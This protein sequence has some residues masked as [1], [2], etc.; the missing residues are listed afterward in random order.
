MSKYYEYLNQN[1][2]YKNYNRNNFNLN[3]NQYKR[4]NSKNDKK[5]YNAKNKI[6]LNFL[7]FIIFILSI[8]VIGKF[9]FEFL[10]IFNLSINSIN[11]TTDLEITEEELA[12]MISLKENNL[13][14]DVNTKEI[15]KSLLSNP[16]IKEVK[17]KKIFP[18]KLNIDIKKREG[19]MISFIEQDNIKK[20][21]AIDEEGI[22]FAV[23]R[24]D[25]NNFDLP[26][27]SGIKFNEFYKGLEFN[28]TI[29]KRFI[30]S[31]HELK[32]INLKLF[33]LISECEIIPLGIDNKDL[34]ILIYL[35]NT[36]IPI[37]IRSNINENMIKYMLYTIDFLKKNEKDYNKIKEID[38]RSDYPVYKKEI[39][40]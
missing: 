24:E 29:I 27:L 1:K 33:S 34:E 37:R 7:I 19:L 38:F 10:I 11:L 28:S 14:Y 17:V 9:L 15:E 22:I 20:P 8:I 6:N 26:I 16:S 32:K 30:K 35:L 23:D 25:I 21:I 2:Q 3:Y 13:Y 36:D 12:E 5:A 4:N 39:K 31:L 40:Q 18:N